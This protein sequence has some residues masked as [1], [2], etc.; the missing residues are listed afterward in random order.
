MIYPELLRTEI[1]KGFLKMRLTEAFTDRG[2]VK[3]A[4]SDFEEIYI[5]ELGGSIKG[6]R[7]HPD[8]SDFEQTFLLLKRRIFE[9]KAW[10]DLFIEVL[11][12]THPSLYETYQ[13][14]KRKY[15]ALTALDQ[16]LLKMAPL[17]AKVLK[18]RKKRL[19]KNLDQETANA[20]KQIETLL[21]QHHKPES[22]EQ[23]KKL[24]KLLK[25]QELVYTSLVQLLHTQ[26]ETWEKLVV[27][28]GRGFLFTD[29]ARIPFSAIYTT[30]GDFYII[31]EVIGHLLGYGFGKVACRSIHLQSG[32]IFALIKPHSEYP[33]ILDQGERKEK[34]EKNFLLTWRESD[35][36]KHFLGKLGILQIRERLAFRTKEFPELYL[37]EDYFADGDLEKHL[38]NL[39]AKKTPP[40]SFQEN[41]Q[42]GFQLL[43]ALKSIHEKGYIHFDIKPENILLDFHTYPNFMVTIADFNTAKAYNE[44]LSY[45]NLGHSTPWCPP[46]YALFHL[47]EDKNAPRQPVGKLLFRFDVWSLGVVLYCLYFGESFPW[48]GLQQEETYRA[49]AQLKTGWI[50]KRL[51]KHIYYPLIEKMLQPDPNHRLTAAQALDLFMQLSKQSQNQ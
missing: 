30:N 39:F 7:R 13:I 15:N 9:H 25:D 19:A 23:E 6:L 18:I 38:K 32:Q 24:F 2:A 46:E 8:K 43:T 10:L 41:F 3:T 14:E 20:L 31:L 48:E 12:Q 33:E 17:E 40:L 1:E 44:Q 50:P 29:P 21:K 16:M 34:I 36:L 28:N 27:K 11:L 5:K 51:H 42:M 49:I 45:S 37:I 35:I 4:I 47:K 22:P 26:F